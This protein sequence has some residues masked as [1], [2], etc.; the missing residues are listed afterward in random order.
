[1]RPKSENFDLKYSIILGVFYALKLSYRQALLRIERQVEVSVNVSVLSYYL[2]VR[3][4]G[5]K[6]KETLF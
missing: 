2:N 1:M 4:L 3:D 5:G 6:D